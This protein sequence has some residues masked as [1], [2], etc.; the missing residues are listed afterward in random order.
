MPA[1]FS[2]IRLCQPIHATSQFI[3]VFS[4][5]RQPAGT[6]GPLKATRT[7]TQSHKQAR[8]SVQN[9]TKLNI[10]TVKVRAAMLYINDEKSL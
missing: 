4:T 9:N 7:E 8:W 10:I 6:L 1:I 3:L 2:S 5:S